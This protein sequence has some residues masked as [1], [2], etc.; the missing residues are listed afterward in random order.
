METVLTFQAIKLAMADF[1]GLEKDALH[2]YVGLTLYLLSAM[3]F[4]LPLRDLRLIGVVFLAAVAGE[5][6]D[7]YRYVQPED[8]P[9]WWSNWHDIWNT[10]FWPTVLF[11][12]ARFTR[13]LK[14]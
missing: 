9:R 10:M 8:P 2:V 4:R 11:G 5:L 12:L 7:L 3:A 1:F 14:R 13:V 6:L